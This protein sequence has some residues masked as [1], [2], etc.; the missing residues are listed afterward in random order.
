MALKYKMKQRLEF[1]QQ[2]TM[3]IGK[4]FFKQHRGDSTHG[5]H[6][7]VKTEVRLIIFFAAED[8]KKL[9]TVSKNKIWS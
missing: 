1:F 9:Y 3:I 7:M 4:I 2:N 6:Q 5:H 8:E